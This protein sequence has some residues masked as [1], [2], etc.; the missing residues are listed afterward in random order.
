MAGPSA[1]AA[2]LLL[3]L[4]FSPWYLF[5]LAVNVALIFGIVW[6]EWPS[7]TTVGRAAGGGPPSPDSMCSPCGMVRAFRAEGAM[8]AG[9][10][11]WELPA[12]WQANGG[13]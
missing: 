12:V 7:E 5:I 2:L 1:P 10:R 8:G 11:K 3:L 4:Y 13:P 9:A 6:M